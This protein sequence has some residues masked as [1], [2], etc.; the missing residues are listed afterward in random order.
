MLIPIIVVGIIVIIVLAIVSMY[1][2]LVRMR[3]RCEESWA[4]VDVQLRRRYDLIPNLVNAV[5]GYMTHERETLENVTKARTACMSATGPKEQGKAEGFLTQ[6]LKS[7]FAVAESYPDLKANQNMLQLQSQLSETEDGIAQMRELYNGAV[8][9]LNNA[10][11][12]VP[13]NFVAMAF[14]FA[15]KEYFEAP[16]EEVREAPKVEF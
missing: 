4:Q 16:E 12:V 8:R 11:Q 6:T 13:S 2:S 9:T 15:V 14:G 3:N 5:K 1:N 10:C 7:L